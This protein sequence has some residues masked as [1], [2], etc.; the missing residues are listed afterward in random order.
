M[1]DIILIYSPV[2]TR[3][4]NTNNYTSSESIKRS[5]ISTQVGHSKK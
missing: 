2:E 1:K 4:N 5:Y 3:A